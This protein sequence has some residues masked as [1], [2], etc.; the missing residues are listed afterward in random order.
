[1]CQVL[2]K[3]TY[4]GSVFRFS[5]DR[6]YQTVVRGCPRLGDQE[7]DYRILLILGNPPLIVYDDHHLGPQIHDI[8]FKA[9][10]IEAQLP[11]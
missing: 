2:C 7:W 11:W 4:G 3:A 10:I 8:Y 9:L 6:G 1:V 5:Q